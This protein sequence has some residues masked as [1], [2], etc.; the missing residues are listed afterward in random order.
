M[1]SH[2][3]HGRYELYKRCT[4][5]V[6]RWLSK[7]SNIR[8]CS[9]R[10]ILDAARA[11]KSN[12]KAVPNHI[13]TDLE[14]AI[15]LR[16]EVAQLHEINESVPSD[17]GHD[18][19]VTILQ[20]TRQLL[21]PALASEKGGATVEATVE[22]ALPNQ[23]EMLSVEETVAEDE[24][25]TVVI[26]GT[27]RV[28]SVPDLLGETESFAAGCFL[29]DLA[30]LFDR[31]TEA[32][33]EYTRDPQPHKLLCATAISNTCVLNAE[34]ITVAL[35]VLFPSLNTLEHCTAAAY[36]SDTISELEDEY[37]LE[38]SLAL[39]IVSD[40]AFGDPKN[41]M[42]YQ[43]GDTVDVIHAAVLADKDSRTG[44]EAFMKASMHMVELLLRSGMSEPPVA[45]CGP[46][47][48]WRL[49]GA[50]MTKLDLVPDLASGKVS[51]W[52][53][54]VITIP[55][56]IRDVLKGIAQAYKSKKGAVLVVSSNKFLAIDIYKEESDRNG[57]KVLRIQY[58]ISKK[59]HEAED[60]LT[61]ETIQELQC[62]NQVAAL[63]AADIESRDDA[64]RSAYGKINASSFDIDSVSG[65]RIY[66]TS[67]ALVSLDDPDPDP[68]ENTGESQTQVDEFLLGPNGILHTSSTV[69]KIAAAG[70]IKEPDSWGAPKP[71][72]FGPIWDER[73]NPARSTAELKDYLSGTLC[74]LQEF[75]HMELRQTRKGPRIEVPDLKMDTLMP[76]WRHLQEAMAQETYSV[77]LIISLHVLLLSLSRV[78]GEFR[79]HR[80]KSQCCATIQNAHQQV[81]RDLRRLKKDQSVAS[82][83][84]FLQ[85]FL[86][87]AVERATVTPPVPPGSMIPPSMLNRQRDQALLM[88]PWVAGQQMLVIS[89]AGGL[90]F[91][92]TVIDCAGQCR[93]VLHIYN[94][95]RVAEVIEPLRLLEQLMEALHPG[96]VIFFGSRPT[97][98]FLKAWYHALGMGADT[99][100]TAKNRKLSAVEAG[101]ISMS[102]RRAALCDFT[103]SDT[104]AGSIALLRE[105]FATDTM[106]GTMLTSIGTHLLDLPCKLVEALG[107]MDKVDA[108]VREQSVQPGSRGGKSRKKKSTAEEGHLRN[109]AMHAVLTQEVLMNCELSVTTDEPFFTNGNQT[110]TS[111]ETLPP[112]HAAQ[113]ERLQLAANV[114]ADFVSAMPPH[115]I[116][117]TGKEEAPATSSTQGRVAAQAEWL[118]GTNAPEGRGGGQ[119]RSRRRG[120]KKR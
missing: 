22:E 107:L 96:P 28:V 118:Q 27:Q 8:V 10:K 120:K 88:N 91:G 47:L 33:D 32:W 29:V 57:R 98:N 105:A 65:L 66:H 92:A 71:G 26:N 114:L 42:M 2:E 86:H 4:G 85:S 39:E 119:G 75:A 19:M 108:D 34:S 60:F 95:L 90:N 41:T 76:F 35:E 113:R 104:L 44:R 112:L 84:E 18:F 6:V 62:S 13:R 36:L 78:N 16:K 61:G 69:Q 55:P 12:M 68:A 102:F 81:T 51:R 58:A 14:T 89:L 23:Y 45:G 20:Q 73:E 79:C 64:S 53:S 93:F 87:Y 59:R 43:M 110:G 37:E 99:K 83:A 49:V 111:R 63:L 97:A 82:N 3:I 38:H 80:L 101:D 48:A 109:S 1:A 15:R 30:E 21:E 7:E 77:T 5:T 100:V 54:T 11:V 46:K 117:A 56:E 70:F 31:I 67:V 9:V 106:V 72:I 50:I 25:T 103:G 40:I 74:A 94:A 116:F 17:E 115:E 52:G 24:S